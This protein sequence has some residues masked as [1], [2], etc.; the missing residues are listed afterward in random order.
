MTPEIRYLTS[1][2]ETLFDASEHGGELFI[3]SGISLD[4]EGSGFKFYVL[5]SH[6]C[7][8]TTDRSFSDWYGYI[9]TGNEERFA[10]FTEL[11]CKRYGVNLDGESLT[12]SITF[13]RNEYTLAQAL[14]RLEGA[15]LFLS[16][17]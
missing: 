17:L 7:R 4:G 2:L 5:D 6:T 15:M 8:I 9:S 12:L 3:H 1:S 13:R 16:E 11:V 14:M 10:R